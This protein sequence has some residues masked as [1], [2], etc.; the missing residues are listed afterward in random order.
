MDAIVNFVGSWPNL[1]QRAFIE[2]S[3]VVAFVTVTAIGIFVI[4]QQQWRPDSLLTNIAFVAGGWLIAVSSVVFVMAVLGKGWGMLEQAMPF[5]AKL[6]GYLYGICERHPVL[7]LAIVG[8]G[9]TTFFLKGAWP[10]VIAW[11]PLRA[12][13][14]LFGIALAIHIAGPIADMVDGEPAAHFASGKAKLEKLALLPVEQALAQA[15]KTGD[16]R[17]M[18]VRH[19]VD[20]VSGYP[21]AEAGKPETA[22]PW[23]IG[24]KP[25]GASC[26][27]SMGH[28][29]SVR[30]N[31]HHAYAAEYNR[32]M[33]EHNKSM[34][35]ELMSAR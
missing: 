13:C 8:A 3:L 12:V 11:A 34:P 30:M 21:A 1:I 25:L 14:A 10:M 26:Y 9:T 24:V 27:E 5:A 20:E 17:Y 18:S 16:R 35:R 19:C 32:R 6:S 15:I 7:A 23:S 2:H 28:E 31:R 22:S 29:G 4:L 33:Y